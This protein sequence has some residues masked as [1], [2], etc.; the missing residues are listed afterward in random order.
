[1]SRSLYYAAVYANDKEALEPYIKNIAKDAA[2]RIR[3]RELYLGRI[4]IRERI[5]RKAMFFPLNSSLAKANAA[6]VMI[7][8]IITVVITVKRKVFN[9][10]LPSGTAVNASL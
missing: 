10:Y 1:M 2:D 6:R 5:N 4:I 8:S 3:R 7:T 9:R